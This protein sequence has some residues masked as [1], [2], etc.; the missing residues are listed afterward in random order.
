[1]DKDD[2]KPAQRQG[3]KERPPGKLA[4]LTEEASLKSR[5]DRS[6]GDARRRVSLVRLSSQER[7]SEE[8]LT[9]QVRFRETAALTK[10]LEDAAR[11]LGLSSVDLSTMP[12]VAFR[13]GVQRLEEMAAAMA[14]ARRRK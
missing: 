8:K 12:R 11:T 10:R 6:T 1:M 3:K 5:S 4:N 14:P 9:E 7:V 2:L 13:L